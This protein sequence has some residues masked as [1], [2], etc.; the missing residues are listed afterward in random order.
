MRH[1][2]RQYRRIVAT[3]WLARL[4]L[5]VVLT[6]PRPPVQ[7]RAKMTRYAL[8]RRLK[9][10]SHRISSRA[11]DHIAIQHD[12]SCA[13]QRHGQITGFLI[14]IS[15]TKT[16]TSSAMCR[17]HCCLRLT[18]KLGRH[19]NTDPIQTDGRFIIS[20]CVGKAPLQPAVQK[21]S[22]ANAAMVPQ[23]ILPMKMLR[24][25]PSSR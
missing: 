16:Q 9:F 7:F 4:P 22:P 19:L 5:E 3:P 14:L 6:P 11:E 1:H 15:A 18:Q 17:P 12:P 24:V 2:L 8:L 13:G 10:P 25:H 23:S 20:S 21:A